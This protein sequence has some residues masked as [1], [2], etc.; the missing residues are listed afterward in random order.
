MTTRG[1]RMINR[2]THKDL[3]PG[4]IIYLEV[5]FVENT[6][7]YYHGYDPSLIIDQP[8]TDRQGRTAKRRPVLVVANEKNNFYYMPI[9]S[10]HR[11]RDSYYHYHLPNN[12]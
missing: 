2:K 10:R 3:Y 9:T 11:Q 1:D 12:K 7:E 8:V 5:P 4:D 6:S